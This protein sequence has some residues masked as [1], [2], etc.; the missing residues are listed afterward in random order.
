M[1]WVKGTSNSAFSNPRYLLTWD[2]RIRKKGRAKGGWP[3]PHV[4][5]NYG[6]KSDVVSLTIIQEV[7]G[8]DADHPK[9]KWSP[10]DEHQSLVEIDDLTAKMRR[11]LFAKMAAEGAIE[12]KPGQP[13]PK[14]GLAS[15]ELDIMP[16][17]G[18]RPDHLRV[19]QQ[20]LLR[21]EW[22]HLS[23]IQ[24]KSMML[25]QVVSNKAEGMGTACKECIAIKGVCPEGGI[26]YKDE[27]HQKLC[28]DVCLKWL[29][30]A[31]TTAICKC[32][33][34]CGAGGMSTKQ[35]SDD[36]VANYLSPRTLFLVP[37]QGLASDRCIA[38]TSA[39]VKQYRAV[40]YRQKLWRPAQ[41]TNFLLSFWWQPNKEKFKDVNA[42]K[43]LRS[44]VYKGNYPYPSGG[45]EKA[46]L[47]VEADL[48][49]G[50]PPYIKVTVGGQWFRSAS[51]VHESEFSFIAITKDDRVVKLYLGVGNNAYKEKAV[52]DSWMTLEGTGTGVDP[53]KSS[54]DD[55]LYL[56]APGVSHKG[57][58]GE[59]YI[60][61]LTLIQAQRW[62]QDSGQ[63]AVT[64]LMHPIP[65]WP[66]QVAQLLADNKPKNCG[67]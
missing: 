40:K 6:H 20:I 41:G 25:G 31:D 5:G 16:Y 57:S 17:Q 24:Q 35:L 29:T 49:S 39:A 52:V 53:Y 36:A 13:R 10:K 38:L 45:I 54:E 59:G 37:A 11:R 56:V 61:K 15:V 8:K 64:N 9:I 50:S 19:E 34:D 32:R 18:M 51:R 65:M 7:E 21:K 66:A 60:G 46:P 28:H 47:H 23:K 1:W 43:S 67:M 62:D 22:N 2:N 12:R 44:L 33:I 26:T 14:T 27:E 63:D 48:T 55:S 58:L 3:S 42:P 4:G 30:E